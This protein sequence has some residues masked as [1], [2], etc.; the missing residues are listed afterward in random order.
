MFGLEP[1]DLLTI[2]SMVVAI[3]WFDRR[4]NKL[5]AD[6]DQVQALRDQRID[7]ILFGMDD[8]SRGLVRNVDTLRIDMYDAHQGEVPRMRH[9]IAAIRTSLLTHD[10]QTPDAK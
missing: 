1:R 10:I 4:R 6:R 3:Y 5:Q 9:H 2:L 8:S 7:Y